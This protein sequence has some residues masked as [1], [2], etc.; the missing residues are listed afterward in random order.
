MSRRKT[1]PTIVPWLSA[2]W[3]N[4]EKRFI[5]VGDS[6][7]FEEAFRK[8][9]VGA[10][11]LYLCMAMESGGRRDFRFPTAAARKYG[12]PSSSFWNYVQ[13]LKDNH[14]IICHSNKNLR[15]PNDYSFTLE[16]KTIRPPALTRP[17]A[18]ATY[19]RSVQNPDK[20]G[21]SDNSLVIQNP[22]KEQRNEAET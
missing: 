5:Q 7:L 20:A 1:R 21:R 11:Y 8:L 9:H 3:D 16:W 4:Q 10:K 2:K 13:E 18:M 6:L 17:E 14:F 19:S 12:I 22:D 15:K